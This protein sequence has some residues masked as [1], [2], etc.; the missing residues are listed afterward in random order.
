MLTLLVC[1]AAVLRP[2]VDKTRNNSVQSH[3]ALL[4]PPPPSATNARLTVASYRERTCCTEP[5]L[6]R[7]RCKRGIGSCGEGAGSWA[8]MDAVNAF[9]QELFSL[10]DSKPP[11]SRAKMIS[12]TKSAIKAMKLYKHV[13]QIVEKFIKKC[14][15]EYKV[16][17]LYVVDS[18]VRQSRHQFGP[19][20]DVF[21]PRFTKNITGTFENLCLC[22]VEDRVRAERI[23]RTFHVSENIVD[24][25]VEVTI[26]LK[27]LVPPVINTLT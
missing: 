23:G 17:G 3:H 20:K 14:K 24:C 7:Q 11:I 13:V 15:P 27:I 22:P 2:L 19:D 5:S 6:N 4:W 18:I 12:I 1:F 26:W 16:A 9:N 10:M 8:I 25:H 21:G